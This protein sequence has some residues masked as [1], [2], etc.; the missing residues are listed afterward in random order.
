MPSP[1][2]VA[3]RVRKRAPT[4]TGSSSTSDS[5]LPRPGRYTT[6]SASRYTA[7]SAFVDAAP[8]GARPHT[9]QGHG[10]G[11]GGSDPAGGGWGGWVGPCHDRS[12][13]IAALDLVAPL[14]TILSP[15]VRGSPYN[16]TLT[17]V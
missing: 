17:P 12:P 10:A 5:A 16:Q 2:S 4:G 14:L 8:L 13:T 1:P 11:A 15:R 7:K 6:R 9:G 3:M